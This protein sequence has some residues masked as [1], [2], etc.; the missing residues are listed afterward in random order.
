MYGAEKDA[1]SNGGGAHIWF[2]PVVLRWYSLPAANCISGDFTVRILDTMKL[3][4]P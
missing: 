3:C 1:V 2:G 4:K